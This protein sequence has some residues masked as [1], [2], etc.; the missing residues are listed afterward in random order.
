[1]PPLAPVELIGRLFTDYVALGDTYGPVTSITVS[2]SRQ[3]GISGISVSV[4]IS[5]PLPDDIDG[6]RFDTG[7]HRTVQRYVKIDGYGVHLTLFFLADA[8]SVSAEGTIL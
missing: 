7:I 1:M 3:P 8:P 4:F 6:D 2:A 5:A